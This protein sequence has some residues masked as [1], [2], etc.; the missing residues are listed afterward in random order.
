M[1]KRF[2]L[3]QHPWLGMFAVMLTWV[4]SLF[5]YIIIATQPFKQTPGSQT[6]VF[7]TN[8]LAHITLL[9]VLVPF[10]LRLPAG[11][12][13]YKTYLDSIRLSRVR[14]FFQLLLLALS[15]Y[16]IQVLCQAG[17][18]LV[19]RASQGLPVTWSFIRITFDWVRLVPS[20]SWSWLNPL[21]SIFE[22]VTF[23]GVVLSLFL[24]RYSKPQAILF[25]AL[26]FGAMHLLNLASDQAPV[27]VF[28]QFVW[29][30]IFGLFYGVLVL[31]ANS[32]WPAMLIHYLGNLFIYPLTAYMQNSASVGTQAVYGILFFFG[33]VP[34]ALMIL[35]IFLYT[36]IWSI[37]VDK[38]S[39]IEG[40]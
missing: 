33:V 4:V 26:G 8:L 7:T 24:S 3:Y 1:T 22:E 16:L 14:P 11:K 39:G 35:W 20:D 28:G 30:T 25:S 17:G 9:F 23:R 31:K 18:V 5:V 21:P 15:C 32:L 19:Y 6:T 2:R 34:T 38:P 10:V 40:A 37:S 27:W 12:Q 13:S 36:R 29:S